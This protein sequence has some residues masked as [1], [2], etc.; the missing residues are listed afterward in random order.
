MTFCSNCGAELDKDA[1]FCPKCGMEIMTI[2]ERSVSE[3]LRKSRKKPIGTMTI[4]LIAIVVIVVIVGLISTVIFLGGW[5]P[6]GEVVGSGNL[7]TKEEF[8]SDFYEGDIEAGAPN[9]DTTNKEWTFVNGD[10]ARTNIVQKEGVAYSRATL[11]VEGT[12]LGNLQLRLSADGGTDFEN[13]TNETQHTFTDTT[14]G[15]IMIE[16]EASGNATITKIKLRSVI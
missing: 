11:T 8:F 13:V 7:V 15:G 3:H 12:G 1:K 14:T 2:S 16:V 5:A 4:A 10:R 6:L 9:W